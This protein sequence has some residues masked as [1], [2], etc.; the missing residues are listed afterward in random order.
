[1]GFYDKHILLKVLNWTCG[2]NPVQK[3][4]QKMVP[5]AECP[6]LMPRTAPKPRYLNVC[7]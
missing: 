3:Q 1:M 2:M 5:L 6:C 7:L 4:R